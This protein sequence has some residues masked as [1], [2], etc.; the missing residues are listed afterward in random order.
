MI[1]YYLNVSQQDKQIFLKD[2]MTNV[3]TNVEPASINENFQALIKI[4]DNFY[5]QLIK[6]NTQYEQSII[7]K[8]YM[9]Y[10]YK[11]LQGQESILEK[12]LEEHKIIPY[13]SEQIHKVNDY[14]PRILLNRIYFDLGDG[15]FQQRQV[16]KLMDNFLTTDKKEFQK[17]IFY[18]PKIKQGLPTFVLNNLDTDNYNIDNVTLFL[19]EGV[20]DQIKLF[21]LITND[22]PNIIVSSMN[23]KTINDNIEHLISIKNVKGI[24]YIPDQ[25]VKF[26]EIERNL[27]KIK[28]TGYKGNIMVGEL[29]GIKDTGELNT[30]QDLKKIK[31]QNHIKYKLKQILNR[32]VTIL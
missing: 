29:D 26:N 15:V 8:I 14:T 16:N 13:F 25:D 21:G 4:S 10:L 17:Y 9:P 31:I 11:R 27:D 24:I 23:G 30:I 32:G 20:F 5:N 2:M 18:K 6:D 7:N 28:Q 22:F 19:V 1:M 12:L 3:T